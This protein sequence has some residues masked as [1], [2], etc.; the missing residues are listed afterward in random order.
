MSTPEHRDNKA[1]DVQAIL[2]SLSEG[3]LTLDDFGRIIGINQPPAT[4]WGCREIV[5]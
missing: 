4:R 2:D 1:P 3:I 5:R